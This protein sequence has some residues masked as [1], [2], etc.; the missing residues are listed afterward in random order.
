MS[1]DDWE[2]YFTVVKKQDWKSAKDVLQR[3]A[4]QEKNNPQ[5]FLKI[6]KNLRCPGK[7]MAELQAVEES[8]WLET[9]SLSP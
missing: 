7:P 1:K 3:I 6:G 4:A 2:T 5:T 9:T 8:S